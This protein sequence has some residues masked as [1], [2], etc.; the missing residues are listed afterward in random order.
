MAVIEPVKLILTNVP[1]DFSHS[2]QAPLFPK[3]LSKGT[4]EIKLTKELYIERSDVLLEDKKDFYGFALG[5]VVG[6]KY[7]FPV[8]VS[9]IVTGEKNEI[10][11]VHAE[12]L[13]DSKEK[14]KGY[15]HWIPVKDSIEVEARLYDVLFLEYNPN[16]LDN[17][18][19]SLNPNS[20]ITKPHDRVH[21][22][23][24]GKFNLKLF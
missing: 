8:K 18:L 14:P 12:L 2:I 7:G 11:A 10:I 5:K 17:W 13:K 15:V 6:L 9:Q 1:E 20:L 3:D 22:D 21:K 4:Y 23:L 24:L 19:D 16:E